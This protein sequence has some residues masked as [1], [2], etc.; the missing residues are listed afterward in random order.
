MLKENMFLNKVIHGLTAFLVFISLIAY[1]SNASADDFKLKTAKEYQQQG[2]DEQQKGNL[3]VALSYYK[4]AI[5]LGLKDADL[6]NEAGILS[7]QAGMLKNAEKYYLEAIHEDEN[8][9]PAYMNLGYLYK[10]IGEEEK[11]LIYFKKR[12]E[13][14]ELDDPWAERAKAEILKIAPS[15]R[16]WFQAV[17]AEQL[18]REMVRR[19]REELYQNL[20]F[21]D[22]CYKSGITLMRRGEYKEAMKTFEQGLEFTP[23]NPKLLD[24]QKKAEHALFQERIDEH[25]D[26]AASFLDAGSYLAAEKEIQKI[27]T[28]LPDEPKHYFPDNI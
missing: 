27:L 17:E 14:A 20:M 25:K 9:L 10:R 13:L 5:S 16:K 22:E 4:K 21:A 6:F 11:A 2:D 7:E 23:N 19:A 24:A 28:I 8:F 1:H 3:P 26:R 15:Y 18:N 12:F